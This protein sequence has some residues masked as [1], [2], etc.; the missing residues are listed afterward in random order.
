MHL[1]LALL[2]TLH[3]LAFF[4]TPPGLMWVPAGCLTKTLWEGNL[5]SFKCALSSGI[6]QALNIIS[7]Q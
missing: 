6:N 5:T 3:A 2:Q 1:H 4:K 7:G